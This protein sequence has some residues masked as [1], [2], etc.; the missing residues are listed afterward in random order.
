MLPVVDERL[1]NIKPPLNIKR[2]PRY[3]NDLKYWKASELRS[4]L[5]FYAPVIL[6]GILPKEHY[7]HFLLFSN[8]IFLLL[9]NSISDSDI[10][11]AENFLEHFVSRF[12]D[13]YEDR[14]MTLNLHLLLHLPA[15]VRN[16]GPLWAYSCFPFEDANGYLLKL[17]KGTQSVESQIIDSVSVTH[18]MPFL[19]KNCIIQG[20]KEEELLKK[21]LKISDKN[22]T[23]IRENMYIMGKTTEKNP[24]DLSQDHLVA[25]S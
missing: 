23:L 3:L 13:L 17:V 20:S 10:T 7:E 19:R 15:N 24:H 18:G 16:L 12:P 6:L 25:D 4:W 5:L 1:E 8:A 11:R 14:C 22:I 21:I 9:K 2:K